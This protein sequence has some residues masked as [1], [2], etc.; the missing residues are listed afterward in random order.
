MVWYQVSASDAVGN[1]SARSAAISVSMIDAAVSLRLDAG[2]P[3]PSRLGAPVH[4]PMMIPAGGATALV[5]IN[6]SGGHR[7]WHRE[8]GNLVSGP[9]TLDWDGKNDAGRDVAPGVYTAWLTAGSSRFSIKLVRV[10]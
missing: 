5:V 1:E 7:V 10:P 2:Y 4:I 9:F 3:N 8:L 6:D